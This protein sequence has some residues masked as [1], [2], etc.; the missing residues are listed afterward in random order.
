MDML[1]LVESKEKEAQSFYLIA[2]SKTA[3][4][5]TRRFFRALAAQEQNHQGLV[6]RLCNPAN[7]SVPHD[8]LT[9]VEDIFHKLV[10]AERLPKTALESLTDIIEKALSQEQGSIELYCCLEELFEST[11][12]K[13][14]CRLLQDEERQHKRILEIF[15]EHVDNPENLLNAAEFSFLRHDEHDS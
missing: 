14:L 11:E 10:R 12:E 7:W 2:A 15:L 6:M 3:H 8:K 5:I 13:H 9:A 1:Q 4:E